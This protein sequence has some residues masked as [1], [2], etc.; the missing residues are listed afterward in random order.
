MRST[1]SCG[2]T[3]LKHANHNSTEIATAAQPPALA[4]HHNRF[5]VAHNTLLRRR[6]SKQHD[7]K[8]YSSA[9]NIMLYRGIR[10]SHENLQ[11]IAK[12]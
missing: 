11:R 8:T 3:K 10:L 9:P 2:D 12:S 7:V 5:Q 4:G 1:L 6:T